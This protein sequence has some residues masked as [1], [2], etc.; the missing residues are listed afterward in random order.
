MNIV[1]NILNLLAALLAIIIFGRLAVGLNYRTAYLPLVCSLMYFILQIEWLMTS[2]GD[3]IGKYR[4]I[5]WCVAEIGLLAG[6][7]WTVWALR[8]SFE[9]FCDIVKKGLEE[10]ED[11]DDANNNIK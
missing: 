2:S 9:E 4:D 8:K 11:K 10:N 3:L 6:A 7:S 1:F 5:A